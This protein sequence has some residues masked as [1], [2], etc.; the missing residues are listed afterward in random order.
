MVGGLH[1]DDSTYS[2][3]AVVGWSSASLALQPIMGLLPQRRPWL[4]GS[5]FT[6]AAIGW[7]AVTLQLLL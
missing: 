1:V 3:R 2:S 6:C 7:E 4:G 5:G